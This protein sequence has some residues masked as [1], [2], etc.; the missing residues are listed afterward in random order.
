L[1]ILVGIGLWY[2]IPRTK[3]LLKRDLYSRARNLNL[4]IGLLAIVWVFVRYEG[5]AIISAHWIIWLLYAIFIIWKA[6]IFRYWQGE[7]REKMLAYEK[8]QQMKKYM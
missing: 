2:L 3:N 4:T 8:Q 5:I 6:N 7:Y 1:M